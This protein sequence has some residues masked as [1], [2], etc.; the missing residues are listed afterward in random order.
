MGRRLL[1]ILYAMVRDG[2]PYRCAEPT[3]RNAA[4]NAARAKKKARRPEAA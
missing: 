2:Q 1:R 3:V 4:A